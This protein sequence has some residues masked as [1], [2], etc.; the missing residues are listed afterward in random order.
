MKG[1]NDDN[2]DFRR[3][4]EWIGELEGIGIRDPGP[5]A[6]GPIME[7]HGSESMAA[8]EVTT[9]EFVDKLSEAA[10][11]VQLALDEQGDHNLRTDGGEEVDGGLE[12]VECPNG[13]TD[14]DHDYGNQ[15]IIG[16]LRRDGVEW[17]YC[18]VCGTD[19][20][21]VGGEV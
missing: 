9:E 17:L 2:T 12:R 6:D 16:E 19:P 10:V 7:F 1:E 21:P 3:S 5:D 11:E 4:G 14:E 20:V 13:C 18:N 15:Q 8:V